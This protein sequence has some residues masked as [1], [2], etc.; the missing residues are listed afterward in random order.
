MRIGLTGGIGAG[1]SVVAARLRE[2]GA[3]VIDADAIA[4]EIMEPGLPTLAEVIARFG[5]NF[6][7]DQGRLR[8]AELAARVFP[9]A[10]ALRDLNSITHPEIARRTAAL[11]AAARDAGVPVLVLDMPLLVENGQAG[12]YDAVVVVSASREERLRR[13]ELRGL[14]RGDAEA[15]MA[16]QA[17][18]QQRLAFA[19]FVIDNSGA[20][21]STLQQ[22]D[23]VW[24][25]LVSGE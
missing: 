25:L 23:A 1:K 24:A 16:A 7:D 11:A 13:L 2:L 19:D 8:R 4:R 5:A 15:R 21:S 17:T 22:V 20:L 12:D 14:A 6:L 9:D 3:V 10:A 18:D